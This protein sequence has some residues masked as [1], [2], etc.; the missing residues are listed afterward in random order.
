MRNDWALEHARRERRYRQEIR[1]MV[2]VERALM[3]E[4][5]EAQRMAE[6][7]EELRVEVQEV[8]DGEV[9]AVCLA[10][11]VRGDGSSSVVVRLPCHDRHVFH[12]SCVRRWLLQSPTCPLDRQVLIERGERPPFPS[13]FLQHRPSEDEE[14]WMRRI[15]W[16]EELH[17]R[18]TGKSFQEYWG[19]DWDRFLRRNASGSMTGG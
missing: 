7:L 2:P 16:F 18:L 3:H 9:C 6:F 17:T 15:E 1:V 11:F 13:R 4:V 14:D 12:G 10:P 8:E 5:R 19:D